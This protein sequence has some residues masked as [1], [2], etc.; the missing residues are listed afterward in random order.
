MKDQILNGQHDHEPCLCGLVH[1]LNCTCQLMAAQHQERAITCEKRPGENKGLQRAGKNGIQQ[2]TRWGTG[3]MEA[4]ERSRTKRECYVAQHFADS[5]P[6]GAISTGCGSRYSWSICC[7]YFAS[8]TR[9]LSLRV[10]VI[11]PPA[12]V[13]SSGTIR[14][15]LMV[16][17]CASFLFRSSTMPR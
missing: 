4:P 3:A 8:M 5:Y 12:T 1:G 2:N 11:S 7:L 10:G 6:T 13:N 14:I 16:S 15:F 9:C 17:K